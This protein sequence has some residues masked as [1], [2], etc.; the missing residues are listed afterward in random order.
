MSPT[1]R[2]TFRARPGTCSCVSSV[3]HCCGSVAGTADGAG[4]LALARAVEREL[5]FPRQLLTTHLAGLG[6][7]LSAVGT[8]LEPAAQE[9]RERGALVLGGRVVHQRGQIVR[10]ASALRHVG[11]LL[12]RGRLE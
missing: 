4:L 11:E 12:H 5:A 6:A 3:Y 1:G 7:D 2:I 8:D 10:A 9:L